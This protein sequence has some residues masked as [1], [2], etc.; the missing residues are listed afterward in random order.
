M[1]CNVRADARQRLRVICASSLSSFHSFVFDPF[2]SDVTDGRTRGRK[3]IRYNFITFVKKIEI[4]FRLVDISSAISPT[5]ARMSVSS[6]K[7]EQIRA[8]ETYII[9]NTL[10]TLERLQLLTN[11]VDDK[12]SVITISSK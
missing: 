8:N 1:L 12:T 11:V 6:R 5:E 2:E 10:I 3:E 4:I 7:Y 9:D